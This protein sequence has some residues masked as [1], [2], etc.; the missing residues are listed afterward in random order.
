[1]LGKVLG[2]LSATRLEGDVYLAVRTDLG[3]VRIYEVTCVDVLKDLGIIEQG[4]VLVL[5]DS[6]ETEVCFLPDE[7]GDFR[8][9]LKKPPPSLPEGRRVLPPQKNGAQ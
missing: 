2:V 1:M 5:D 6:L 8:A 7:G 4:A 9:R 3:D